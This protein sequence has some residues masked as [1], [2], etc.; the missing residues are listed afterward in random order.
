[1]SLPLLRRPKLKFINLILSK[2]ASH[3]KKTKGNIVGYS[4]YLSFTICA[5]NLPVWK[6]ELNE[7]L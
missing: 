5:V 4:R 6:Y 1:M 2:L 7:N 3:K